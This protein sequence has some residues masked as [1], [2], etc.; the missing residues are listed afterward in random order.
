MHRSLGG[1]AERTGSRWENAEGAE[2]RFTYSEL[3]Q[4][5]NQFGNVLRKNGIVKGDR[6]LIVMPRIPEWVIAMISTLKIGAIP[7]P[8][9]RC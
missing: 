9:S 8:S 7:I 5:S 3:S 1:Q 6:V 2:R 4:L